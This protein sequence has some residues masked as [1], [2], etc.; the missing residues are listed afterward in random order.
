MAEQEQQIIR[1]CGTDVPGNS[2]IYP[3]LTRIKGVSWSMANAVCYTLKIDKKKKVYKLTEEEI[4]KIIS[5]IQN[6]K[7]PEWLLNRRKD[8]ETGETKHL[9]TNELDMKKDLDIRTMKKMRCYRGVRHA[10]GQPVRGQRTR[11]HFRAKKRAKIKAAKRPE[12]SGK[13]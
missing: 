1:I 2:A 6:P 12:S 13:T 3:G 7:L 8:K 9:I 10:M 4:K 11:S 5:F